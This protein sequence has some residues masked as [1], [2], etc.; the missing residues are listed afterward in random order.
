MKLNSLDTLIRLAG[1]TVIS[2][3]WFTVDSHWQ[4]NSIL[5]DYLSE[6]FRL[7]ISPSDR[8]GKN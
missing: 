4:L 3:H 7:K 1:L 6:S 2:T 5:N 8:W